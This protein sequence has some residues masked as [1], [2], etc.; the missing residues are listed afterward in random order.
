MPGVEAQARVAFAQWRNAA[1]HNG[2]LAA[3][4]AECSRASLPDKRCGV[5]L[6][7]LERFLHTFCAT[8]LLE[9]SALSTAD[10]VA[11][12]VIPATTRLGKKGC[13]CLK[14]RR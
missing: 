12:I 4:G 11:K 2:L 7:W 14:G 5:S 13:A 9:A 10:L 8:E 3:D 6:D 1:H